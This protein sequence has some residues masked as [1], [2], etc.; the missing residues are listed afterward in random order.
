MPVAGGKGKERFNSA[1]RQFKDL[2]VRKWEGTDGL[3]EGIK[4]CSAFNGYT[5]YYLGT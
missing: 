4:E 1:I 2:K 3:N 5:T